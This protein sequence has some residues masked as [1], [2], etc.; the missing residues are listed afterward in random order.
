LLQSDCITNGLNDD[1]SDVNN[2]VYGEK[3]AKSPIPSE[4]MGIK[5]PP[6]DVV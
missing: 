5:A 3:S 2:Q 6:P 1:L 4:G